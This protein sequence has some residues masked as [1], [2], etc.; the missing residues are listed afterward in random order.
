LLLQA[1]QQFLINLQMAPQDQ[2]AKKCLAQIE[3]YEKTPP[4]TR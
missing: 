2:I 1:K 4:P 3:A